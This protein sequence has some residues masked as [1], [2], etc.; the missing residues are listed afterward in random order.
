MDL[1]VACWHEAKA[2]C[3]GFPWLHSRGTNEHMRALVA[4]APRENGQSA[5]DPAVAMVTVEWK[6][7]EVRYDQE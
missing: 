4:R 6:N 1:T 5:W 2:A 7:A 3:F